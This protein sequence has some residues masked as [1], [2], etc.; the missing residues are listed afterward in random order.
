MWSEHF[1]YKNKLV[2]VTAV[3]HAVV[4]ITWSITID[5]VLRHSSVASA[6]ADGLKAAIALA[7]EQAKKII[8]T[9]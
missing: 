1:E 6:S 2:I 9:E 4:D 3:N 5:G 8:D 7:A